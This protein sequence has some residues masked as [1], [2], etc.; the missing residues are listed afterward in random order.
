M[1]FVHRW[2]PATSPDESRVALVLHGT[3][4]DEH[5]LVP[6][7][8]ALLPGA[9]VLSLRGRVSENGAPRFFRRFTEGV[10]DF[11][12]IRVQADALAEFLREA[13]RDRDFDLKN[14]VA[15]GYSN[16]A[17]MAVSTLLTNPD[18]IAEM[19]LFRPQLV[20]ADAETPLHGKRAFISAGRR[21]P[22]V[23][24]DSVEALVTL[25]TGLGADVDLN[26][27]EGGHELSRADIM[28]ASAWLGLA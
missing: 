1:S 5:S 20:L 12:D 3:G 11:D 10:F 8:Q 14:I 23:P 4:G 16:G 7:A 26:W 17:N 25:L 22:I 13:A 6:F 15:I 9:A 21:D 28:A 19:V 24:S 2:D 27:S 18:V